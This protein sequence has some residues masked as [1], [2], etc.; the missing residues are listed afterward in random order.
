[1]GLP[2]LSLNDYTMTDS[3]V[4]TSSDE[5]E[6]LTRPAMLLEETNLPVIDR[7]EISEV[8][9]AKLEE[10]DNVNLPRLFP[11]CIN[12]GETSRPRSPSVFSESTKPDPP[13][14]IDHQ[15]LDDDDDEELRVEDFASLEDEEGEAH[16]LPTPRI[17][18]TKR[19]Q[20]R[21]SV[22]GRI[23]QKAL[24]YIDV[25]HTTDDDEGAD[26]SVLFEDD[27]AD[28][29]PSEVASLPVE[30]SGEEKKQLASKPQEPPVVD[31]RLEEVPHQPL[32]QPDEGT[33]D[34][35]S[36]LPSFAPDPA[37]E[38]SSSVVFA[39]ET[40]E[41]EEENVKSEHTENVP[42][43]HPV[44]E[45]SYGGDDDTQVP[46]EGPTNGQ[47]GLPRS[48]HGELQRQGSGLLPTSSWHTPSR[49]LQAE[50]QPV[51]G[52]NHRAVQAASFLP[53][54]TTYAPT[55]A[56]GP[57][58]TTFATPYP[59]P[60]ATSTTNTPYMMMGNLS[61]AANGNSGGR[62][63]IHLRLREE[64]QSPHKRRRSSF[65]G[66]IR[67]RS[68]RM[69]GVESSLES[70]AEQP[71]FVSLERG[72]LSVSW[73]VGTSAV[74]L[75]EHVRKSVLRKLRLPPRTQLIDLRLLDESMSPPEGKE[76]FVCEDPI[77]LTLRHT[78]KL[79]FV[80]SC[81]H[82]NC[83]LSAHS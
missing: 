65:L 50:R 35:P 39:A 56:F 27:E 12:S 41:G 48:Q 26:G 18:S 11:T 76:I 17:G 34:P 30:E 23:L 14:V 5:E 70:V 53:N 32:E 36:R 52:S 75:Q 1:M 54:T 9:T 25:P 8:D 29:V 40:T 59:A 67:R 4:L 33:N 58:P 79:S 49:S 42:A 13:S 28:L 78:S 38:D 44:M 43:Q 55:P 82:R 62:R 46:R 64:V 51:D 81:I 20:E 74:D 72:L 47:A 80:R 71:E 2:P 37:Q 63:K 6:D 61:V 68:S 7:H 21:N 3:P 16:L 24:A 19:L 60:F 77:R 45:I 15:V 73:Y 31:A 66:H 10:E 69:L 57:A 83:S 22:D